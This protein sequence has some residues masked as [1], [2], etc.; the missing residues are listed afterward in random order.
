M[1]QPE[2]PDTV[3][4]MLNHQ[5]S[6]SAISDRSEVNPVRAKLSLSLAFGPCFSK[7]VRVK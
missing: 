1:Q 5:S 2:P 4:S 6:A 7:T 3:V